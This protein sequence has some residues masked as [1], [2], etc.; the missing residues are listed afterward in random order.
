MHMK[1]QGSRK[2]KRVQLQD[3]RHEFEVLGMKDNG[4]VEE[5][6]ARTPTIANKMIAQGEKLGQ[7]II[8]EKTLRS[9]TTKFNYVVCSI[10]E[11]NDTTILFIDDLQSSLSVHEQMMMINQEKE[12]EHVLKIIN[13]GRGGGNHRGRGR[14]GFRGRG[15]GRQSRDHI[16][17]YN[18]HKI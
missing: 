2:V 14:G 6:I 13:Y 12:E 8:V 10:K 3:L 4:S 17:C 1:Y 5:D 9:M 7:I 15:R 16:E 18:C 11:S